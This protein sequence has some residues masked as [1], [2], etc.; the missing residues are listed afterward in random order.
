LARGRKKPLL[1]IPYILLT[2]LYVAAFF[3][4]WI[5]ELLLLFTLPSLIGVGVTVLVFDYLP[6]HPHKDTTRYGN[7]T[8]YD[9]P[10]WNWFFMGHSFHIVH[11]LWPSIPWYRYR[12]VYSQARTELVAAGVRESNVTQQLKNL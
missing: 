6:H 4:G 1:A 12:E 2:A 3:G 7:A 10:R 8:V 5:P 9:V 11:H